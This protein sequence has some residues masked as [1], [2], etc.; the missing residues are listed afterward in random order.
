MVKTTLHLL[1]IL[2]SITWLTCNGQGVGDACGVDK[3]SVLNECELEFFD[4]F[5]EAEIFNKT[6]HD[7]RG[8]RFAFISSGELKDKVEFFEGIS[9]YKGPKGFDFFNQDQRTKTGY[10]GV[11]VINLKMYN[12]N[13]I[14]ELILNQK[15][16]DD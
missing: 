4:T 2:L 8:K 13:D 11:I 10:D 5:F 7:F 6:D 14:I 3:K 15:G 1:I 12:I 16:K 9:E